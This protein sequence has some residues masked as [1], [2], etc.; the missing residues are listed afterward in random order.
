MSA[1]LN[2][3]TKLSC[4][5]QKRTASDGKSVCGTCLAGYESNLKRSGT[6]ATTNP[7]TPTNVNVFY[8]KP[9]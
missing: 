6:P 4:G 3:G 2:C 1:C 5:C 9:K 8:K 7:T